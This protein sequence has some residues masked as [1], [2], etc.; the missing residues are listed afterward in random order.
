MTTP[1]KTNA[2]RYTFCHEQIDVLYDIFAVQTSMKYFPSG[3]YMIDAPIVEK[4]VCSICF[5][6]GKTF[7]VLMK[8]DPDNRGKLLSAIQDAPKYE[9][10]SVSEHTSSDLPDSLLLQLLL[11]ALGNSEH[12][13]LKCNNLTG[14][15]YCFHPDWIKKDKNS[16]TIWQVPCLEIGV[17]SDA[18][19][20]FD[21]RT[22]TSERLKKKITFKKK[23]FEDYPK[24]VFSVKNTLRRQV[25]GDTGDQFILR[26][27]DGEKT[28]F[29]HF[30]ELGSFQG[31]EKSKMGI[32]S[33]IMLQFHQKYKD[34]AEIAFEDI[35]EYDSIDY[36]RNTLKENN[37]LISSAL[38]KANIR[39][40]D[41][42]GDADSQLFCENLHTLLQEKYQVDAPIGKRLRKDALNLYLIHNA[43]YYLDGNDPHQKQH[44][45]MVIQ[46]ITFEDF[47]GNEDHA[48]SMVIH[49]LLIKADMQEKKFRLFDWSSLRLTES[50][51]FGMAAE[52]D[53]TQ[54]YFFMHIHPDGTFSFSEQ[55]PSLFE[56][57]EYSQCVDIFTAARKS[58]ETLR[59]IIQDNHGNINT[60]EDTGWITIPEIFSIREELQKGNTKIR[61]KEKREQLFSSVIDIKHF[62]KDGAAYYFVGIIGYGMNRT[63]H[64]AANIRKI[65]PVSDAPLFFKSLLPL[66]KVTFVRNNQLTVIPFP[67]KYLREYIQS[68]GLNCN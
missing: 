51:T 62:E 38:E 14:H 43:S 16:N 60:I 56:Q 27:V 21:V 5:Q 35:T 64:T 57:T 44:P 68:L 52:D 8:H 26:Q 42:I 40:V 29:I 10:I 9:T 2:L 3:A 28:G 30:M 50:L 54:R 45:E 22:F 18:R 25:K 6:D 37:A 61:G 66:M 36:D 20:R 17:T 19:L 49:E 55:E 65:E 12:P 47:W 59:G 4:N 58:N 13:F 34:C 63:L 39:I 23:K 15:L 7:Y 67:F 48:V 53:L 41:G 31:F 1:I 46:H 32:V 24:Y 11:N 33:E